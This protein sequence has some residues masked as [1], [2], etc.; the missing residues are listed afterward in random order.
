MA[1]CRSARARYCAGMSAANVDLVRRGLAASFARPPDLATLTALYDPDHVLTSDWGVEGSTY[2][3]MEGFAASLVEL[4]AAW[5]DW[6][7]EAEEILDAGGETV[8]A[9]MRLKAFGRESGAPVDWPW[10]MVITVR[11]GRITASHTHLDRDRALAAN[12]LAG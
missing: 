1:A 12:G 8:V 10:A 2:V 7:L 5:E 6:R 3:G 11:D 4:D 9:L